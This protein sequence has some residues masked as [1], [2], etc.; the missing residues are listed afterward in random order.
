M[1]KKIIKYLGIDWGEVRTGLATGD[2]VTKIAIPR[3]VV[4]GLK[5]LLTIIKKD[6][7]SE[8]VLGEPKKLL[9][10]LPVDDKWKEFLKNLKK[11]TK[12][13]IYLIDERLTSRAADSL[14]GKARDKAQRDAIAAQ[15]ILQSYLDTL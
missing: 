13:K 9:G 7:I 14:P 10:S 11:K 5:E 8:L 1:D 3:G 12:L 2:S 4:F 15:L 6:E